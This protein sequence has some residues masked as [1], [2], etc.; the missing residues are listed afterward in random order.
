MSARRF[1]KYEGLGNDF[2]VLDAREWPEEVVNPALAV[3]LCDRH[4]GVGGDGIL[5]VDASRA[6][7]SAR[8]VI[9][10]ADGSR[11]EMC[12][13]GVRCVAAWLA[14]EGRIPS[15]ATVSIESDAGPRP[16]TLREHAD[17]TASVEVAMGV[18]TVSDARPRIGAGGVAQGVYVV[19]VGNPHGVLFDPRGESME[20]V[21]AV[22]GLKEFPKGVNVE[23][24]T[25]EGDGA[26]RVR[27][28]ERG[29]GWTQ[30]C[31]TGACAVV[32]AAVRHGIVKAGAMTRVTLDGGDLEIR[33]SEGDGRVTMRGPAR[34]VFTGAWS[35][36]A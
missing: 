25:V 32:A 22:T 1:A 19:D 21:R 3:A 14:D 27:V 23:F 10:N 34:R 6:P 5:W 29:V 26:L 33:V 8:M 36:R 4:R 12:G 35:L 11:P 15:G 20:L 30:A 24:V 31:G 13:N 28:H 17:G 18:A 16:A 2:L 9:Y 7:V